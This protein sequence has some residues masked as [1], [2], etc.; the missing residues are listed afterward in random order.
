VSS[1]AL[2]FFASR[3]RREGQDGAQE[4]R[5]QRQLGVAGV[6]LDGRWAA[7]EPHIED[8]P[9]N[10]LEDLIAP[11]LGLEYLRVG[12]TPGGRQ[13]RG[14]G[15]ELV[16]AMND[17]AG[18]D[19]ALAVEPH[20]RNRLAPVAKRT[21]QRLARHHQIDAAVVDRL[22]LQCGFDR[23]ARVRAGQHIQ[24]RGHRAECLTAM[25]GSINVKP[26]RR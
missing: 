13:K 7:Q 14:V 6:A 9:G 3:P 1:S 8:V 12:R 20:A 11:L 18:A 15:D 10:I 26:T 22:Q 16:E 24:L 25:T 2:L 4:F 19:Q 5:G 17:R 21:D 23:G